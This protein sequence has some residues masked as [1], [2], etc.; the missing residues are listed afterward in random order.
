ML[1]NG[2]DRKDLS[3]EQFN[4]LKSITSKYLYISPNGYYYRPL[5]NTCIDLDRDVKK[6]TDEVNLLRVKEPNNQLKISFL[7]FA[8]EQVLNKY[9]LNDCR[10]KIEETRFD[11]SGKVITKYAIKSEKKVLGKS[12][13]EN[14]IYILIGATVFI[15]AMIILLKKKK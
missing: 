7:L 5:G 13:L 8:K 15:T 1:I 12:N 3:S 9:N 6:I 11:E 14:N 10:N 2:L 4:L